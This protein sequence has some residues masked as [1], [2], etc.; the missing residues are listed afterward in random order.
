MTVFYFNQLL[1]VT[2]EIAGS[3]F[4]VEV[5]YDLTVC[6]SPPTFTTEL[7]SLSLSSG[8]EHSWT[9]PLL[10]PA[11][12]LSIEADPLIADH[13]NFNS[14]TN[15]ITYTGDP[16]ESLTAWKA[17]SIQINF[18]D[19]VCVSTYSQTVMV[20]PPTPEPVQEPEEEVVTEEATETESASSAGETTSSGSAN[21]AS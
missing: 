9:L 15:K 12:T 6:Y 10:E 17:V 1:G 19:S 14:I 5:T 4:Q 2:S 3:P 21:S 20:F 16:I 8:E 11:T 13:I 18:V 7:T